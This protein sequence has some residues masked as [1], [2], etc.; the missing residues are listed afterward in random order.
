MELY[1]CVS[2]DEIAFWGCMFPRKLD[3]HVRIIRR[4]YNGK[5]FEIF[6]YKYDLEMRY[7]CKSIE[8]MFSKEELNECV[9]WQECKLNKK[10]QAVRGYRMAWYG[11][12]EANE[13]KIVEILHSALV[14]ARCFF[15]PTSAEYQERHASRVQHL[16]GIR[17]LGRKKM[18]NLIMT[19]GDTDLTFVHLVLRLK[20]QGIALVSVDVFRAWC[21]RAF[22]ATVIEKFISAK[23]D[24]KM[25]LT[26]ALCLLQPVSPFFALVK[27]GGRWLHVQVQVGATKEHVG[28]FAASGAMNDDFHRIDMRIGHRVKFAAADGCTYNDLKYTRTLALAHRVL[29]AR[30]QGADVDKAD[31]FSRIH[32]MLMFSARST[33]WCD[34]MLP[35]LYRVQLILEGKHDFLYM[36]VKAA[37]T[38]FDLFLASIE[39]QDGFESEEKADI[40]RQAAKMGV[41]I[42]DE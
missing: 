34:A 17:G 21:A 4:I 28:D 30:H 3:S 20:M 38:N 14:F 25:P 8:Q 6:V 26:C 24:S 5:P 18:A 1:T 15:F 37:L 23:E 2:D 19:Y 39:N 22:D 13:T 29:R 11:F 35:V 9:E 16:F 31:D 27:E 40:R 32:E 41:H 10:Q 36:D 42:D 12:F 33:M 7:K